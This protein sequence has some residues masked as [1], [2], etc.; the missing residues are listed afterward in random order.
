MNEFLKNTGIF[1]ECF[2]MKNII[3]NSLVVDTVVRM[4]WIKGRFILTNFNI[5][6]NVG[7]G[8]FYLYYQISD[9]PTISPSL[10]ETRLTA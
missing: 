3:L 4:S 1:L 10:Y 8:E 6:D 7:R 9:Q 5:I 2:S